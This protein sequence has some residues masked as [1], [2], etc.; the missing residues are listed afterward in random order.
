MHAV[1]AIVRLPKSAP[2][3]LTKSNLQILY[4]TQMQQGCKV[5]QCTHSRTITS[6]LLSEEIITFYYANVCPT[7]ETIL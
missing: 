1:L 2:D 5:K 7:N 3:N 4:F 6:M